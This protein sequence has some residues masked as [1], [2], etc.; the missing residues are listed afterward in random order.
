VTAQQ[1]LSAE[2]RAAFALLAD[3]MIPPS[4]TMPSATGADAHG[5]G[6]DAV[7]RSRPDLIEA[8]RSALDALAAAAPGVGTA[9]EWIRAGGHEDDW[10]VLSTVVVAAYFLHPAV[11]EALGYPGQEAIPVDKL[12]DD[13]D[14]G[15]LAQVRA[16]GAV[17]R[18]TPPA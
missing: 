9:L 17:Y 12:A 4:P 1:Q 6:L 10:A 7:L 14:P 13:I 5:S 3:E 2:Q 18:P 11:R 16:R 15:E 8:L